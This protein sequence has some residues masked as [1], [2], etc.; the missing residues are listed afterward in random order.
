MNK[1]KTHFLLLL[2]AILMGNSSFAQELNFSWAKQY[3]SPNNANA[4]KSITSDNENKVFVFT[5][6]EGEFD[7][8]E[9]VFVAEGESDLLLYAVSEDGELEWAITEGAQDKELA[10]DVV[11]DAD[12]NVY[13]MGKFNNT[14]NINDVEYESNGTFDM[15]MAKYSN[16]GEFIWCKV[17]GG[18]N[19][20]SLVS[21]KIRYNRIVV[22]GRFYNYTVIEEDTLFSQDGTDAF[23][24]KFNLQGDLLLSTSFGGESVDM[25]SDMDT[26]K[27]GNIYVVGDFYQ[28][29]TFGDET[30][31][32]GEMLG[33]YVAK[34]DAALH[35]QWAQQIIGDD[36]KPEVKIGVSSDGNFAIG[37]V[38]TGG[39]QFGS[40]Q[41]NTADVDEDIYTA[42][43]SSDGEVEWAKRFYSSSME[44]VVELE[45][46]RLGDVYLSGHY[47]DDI[48]FDNLVFLYTLC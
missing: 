38:F 27:Y 37:G 6:F 13:I 3:G 8:G 45:M 48:H 14:L 29:I 26:D 25:I 1:Y 42:Y 16:A 7:V 36:M 28:N 23:I 5:D 41:L 11:C 10:Q 2:F 20:E 39:I 47:G 30:F 19:S 4:V 43:Y 9:E 18:P 32:A 12:G 22:A 35:L 21:M 44:Y 34:Y 31:E 46:D 24:A 17:F 33:L 40:Y 15:F